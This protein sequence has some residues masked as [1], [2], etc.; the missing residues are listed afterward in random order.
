VV[1]EVQTGRAF[2]LRISFPAGFQGRTGARIVASVKSNQAQSPVIQVPIVQLEP[3]LEAAP[4]GA[5]EKKPSAPA[6]DS[7]GG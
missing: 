1:Q 5:P 7:A 6:P 2:N 4:G 3:P